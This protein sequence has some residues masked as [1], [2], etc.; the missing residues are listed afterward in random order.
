[1]R[2]F[3]MIVSLSLAGCGCEVSS[4]QDSG[5]SA[6][7]GVP[8]RVFCVGDSNTR[9]TG[10]YCDVS[11]HNTFNAGRNG[12]SSPWWASGVDFP[13]V[14]GVEDAHEEDPF[15]VCSIMLGSNDALYP[16]SQEDYGQNIRAIV[17]KCRGLGVRGVVLHGPLGDRLGE[18]SSLV[19]GYADVLRDIAAESP[20]VSFGQP[21]ED[22]RLE[23]FLDD[24]V[25]D[26]HLGLLSHEWLARRT[27]QD[28]REV[29]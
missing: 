1:M 17:G 26:F 22:L 25:D 12:T 20:D 9:F 29:P 3:I 23:G 6:S 5:G 15:E 2:G 27:D 10:S 13:P 19:L 11:A 28:L 16:I 14:V 24:W 4:E 7:E 8:L 18:R 21:L